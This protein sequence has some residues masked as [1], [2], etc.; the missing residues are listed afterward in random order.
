MMSNPFIL[1]KDA[2]L[3]VISSLHSTVTYGL[4]PVLIKS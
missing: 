2:C 1:I 3:H 4:C